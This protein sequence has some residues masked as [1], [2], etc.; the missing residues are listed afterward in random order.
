M[1]V[2]E[3]LKNPKNTKHLTQ[4]TCQFNHF[5]KNLNIFKYL[6]KFQTQK[7]TKTTQNL[8]I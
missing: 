1:F 2:Y 4:N 8:R 3:T 5:F 7:R 6:N